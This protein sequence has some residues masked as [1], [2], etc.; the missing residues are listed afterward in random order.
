M[1]LA[2]WD[3]PGWWI[4]FVPIVWALVI[5]AF[6]SVLRAVFFRGGRGLGALGWG[7]GRYGGPRNADEVL[8]RRFAGGELSADEYRERRAV[9]DERPP[10]TTETTP[11]E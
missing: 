7:G 3:G 10:P 6:A 2:D 8:R 1:L 9:L 11:G 4:V 5:V